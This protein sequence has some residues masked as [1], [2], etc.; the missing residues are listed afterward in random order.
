MH[1]QSRDLDLI[2]HVISACRVRWSGPAELR[3]SCRLICMTIASWAA[4]FLP[5]HVLDYCQLSSMIRHC[6]AP[7]LLPADC[8]VRVC[9]AL[10]VLPP[11]VPVRSPP[12]GDQPQLI[13]GIRRRDI[14]QISADGKFIRTY[15]ECPTRNIEVIINAIYSTTIE[16]EVPM[17]EDTYDYVRDYVHELMNEAPS[18]ISVQHNDCYAEFEMTDYDH[19]LW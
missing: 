3:D 19:D 6:W 8:V 11:E 7:C 17:N 14:L 16:I 9:S 10:W 15:V 12:A 13:Q 4:W 1:A 2:S 18:Y 5:G